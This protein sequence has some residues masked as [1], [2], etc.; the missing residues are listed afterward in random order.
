MIKAISP[1][2][3]DIDDILRPFADRNQVAMAIRA[4]IGIIISRTPNPVATPLPPSNAKNIE[5]Q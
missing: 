5:K 3:E 2:S 4:G 1:I